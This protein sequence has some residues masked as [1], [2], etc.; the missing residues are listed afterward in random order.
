MKPIIAILQV[1][2]FG[3]ISIDGGIIFDT[4]EYLIKYVYKLETGRYKIKIAKRSNG[5]YRVSLGGFGRLSIRHPDRIFPIY[6]TRKSASTLCHID[7]ELL[8]L[9]DGDRISITV[10]P[11]KK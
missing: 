9:K 7:K 3:R 2:S 1:F 4:D 11:M 8:K 10:S 5:I 6:I